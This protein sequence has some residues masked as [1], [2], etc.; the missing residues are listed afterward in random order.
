M[1]AG[2]NQSFSNLTA[3]AGVFD[4]RAHMKRL[5][6]LFTTLYTYYMHKYTIFF[7]KCLTNTKMHL[8]INFSWNFAIKQA[9]WRA[10]RK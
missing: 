8:W 7:I 2:R 1:V 9:L 10:K 3:A 6:N 4:R 5:I